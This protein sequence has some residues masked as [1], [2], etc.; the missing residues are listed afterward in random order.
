MTALSQ[1][2]ED[3]L[4]VRR[5]LGFKLTPYGRLLADF[6]AYLETT[7]ATTVTT[8]AAVAW[9]IQ[10]SDATSRWHAQRLGV[11]RGFAAHLHAFDPT[12][13][14]PPAGLLARS[15]RR[16]EPHLYS[17]AEVATLMAE[18]R[19]LLPPL[20]G[21]TY[22]T[23]IGLIAV[24]GLRPGEALRLDCHDIDW[25]DG[26]VRIVGTKFGKSR[27]VPLQPTT[28]Q[29]LSA[30]GQVRDERWP[31][32]RSASFFVS[33]NGTRLA[34]SHVDWTFRGL[35]RR[36]GITSPPNRRPPRLN[37][38]R[39]SFSVK[40][41]IGWYRAGVDVDAHMPLLSTFLGHSNPSHTYWYLSASPELLSLAAGR[42]ESTTGGRS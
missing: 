20:R 2:V 19:A 11:V 33:S 21:A 10:P 37:D 41:L 3:Y 8:A 1:A 31:E 23:L 28:V 32:R 25:T 27:D 6:V 35:L 7:G 24:C 9:A 22:E 4:A 18:A 42:R 39:H 12:A 14:V 5:S 30:Y 36:A 40:T 26:L 38:L 17:D 13:E 16:A 29:A 15:A 34:H